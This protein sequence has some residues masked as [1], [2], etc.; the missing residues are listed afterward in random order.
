MIDTLKT[1]NN[2]LKNP[3]TKMKLNLDQRALYCEILKEYERKVII[4]NNIRYT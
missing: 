2:R 4:E 3:N 1:S